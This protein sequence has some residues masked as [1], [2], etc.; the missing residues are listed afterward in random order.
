M[1]TRGPRKASPG[2]S[3]LSV[4][5]TDP[6]KLGDSGEGLRT[7]M[8]EQRVAPN[9]PGWALVRAGHSLRCRP[10]LPAPF[11]LVGHP[12]WTFMAKAPF[13]SS[14]GCIFSD[15]NRA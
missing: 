9:S 14:S 11:C 6:G 1:A 4:Q 13:L 8:G 10:H 7:E 2:A 12:A 15:I 5:D 3:V